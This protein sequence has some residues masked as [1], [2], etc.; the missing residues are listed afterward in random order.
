MRFERFH[1]E[2]RRR[3]QTMEILPGGAACSRFLAFISLKME[4]HWRSTPVGKVLKRL[5]FFNEAAH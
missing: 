1:N 4:L 3:I 2:F 5:P